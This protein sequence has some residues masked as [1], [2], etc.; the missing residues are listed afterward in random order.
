MTTKHPDENEIQ[1]FVLNDNSN[2]E[3]GEHILHCEHCTLKAA[4]YR[5]L[6]TAIYQQQA[7]VFDFDLTRVVMK[8][9]PKPKTRFSVD[10]LLIPV[11]ISIIVVL[12]FA[13][14][15]FLVPFFPGVL[16]N[17]AP[18]AISLIFTVAVFIAAGIIVGMYR[19]HQKQI[20]IINFY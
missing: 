15:F 2:P 19:R 16:F 17:I 12:L 9:I 6:F 7:P 11:V 3:V 4:Q 20:H 14:L 5:Q 13:L 18:V 8:Q 10:K 1:Y